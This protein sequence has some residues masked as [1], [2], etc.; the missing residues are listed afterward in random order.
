MLRFLARI[1]RANAFD[2]TWLNTQTLFGQAL[3]TN[4][5][6]QRLNHL[7]STQLV[8]QTQ[9]NQAFVHE[10]DGLG[11]AD[12]GGSDCHL[13]SCLQHE[14]ADDE[15]GQEQR[16]D[17]LKHAFWGQ[18]AQGSC[19]Q[20]QVG[21]RLVNDQFDMPT[22]MIQN[23]Q[24]FCR[25]QEGIKQSGHESIDLCSCKTWGSHRISNHPYQQALSCMVVLVLRDVG[26]VRTIPQ[27]AA[28]ASQDVALQPSQH[29]ST[30]ASHEHDGSACMKPTV[31]QDQALL[32][33]PTLQQQGQATGLAL[34][35]GT[36][37]CIADQVGCTFYQQQQTRLGKG[38]VRNLIIGPVTEGF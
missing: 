34:T 36:D 25:V 7:L 33:A 21:T 6:K 27:I 2:N 9:G 17:L 8:H 4:L 29:M 13:R 31:P 1:A 16:I 20:T 26:Q 24:F 18:R 37:F 22:L 10:T 14:R 32:H 11:K 19:R 30:T 15:M 5:S 38:T 28:G 3:L 12:L 23:R 35:T